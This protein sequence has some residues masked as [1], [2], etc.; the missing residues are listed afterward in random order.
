MYTYICG[1]GCYL[2]AKSCLTLATPWTVALQ[3]FLSM[4]LPR[5]EHWSELFFSSLVDHLDPG[6]ESTSSAL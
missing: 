4:G 5:Q 6:I 1:V 2:V 3:P